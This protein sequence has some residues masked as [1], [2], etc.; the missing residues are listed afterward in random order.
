MLIC[1]EGVDGSGKTTLAKALAD[2]MNA[3]YIKMP[4]YD[5]DSVTAPIIKDILSDRHGVDIDLRRKLF[6]SLSIM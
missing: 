3:W 6:G 2:K 4:Y 5:S 1:I